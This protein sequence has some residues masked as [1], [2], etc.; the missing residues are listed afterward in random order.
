MSKIG[1]FA[2]KNLRAQP[3]SCWLT[4]SRFGCTVDFFY[5]LVTKIL[6]ALDSCAYYG[7]A[8]KFLIESIKNC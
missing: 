2:S 8:H 1:C 5:P 6:L 7:T 4:V 3:Q